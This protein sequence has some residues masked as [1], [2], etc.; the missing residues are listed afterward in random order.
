MK[1]LKVGSK[2][3]KRVVIGLAEPDDFKMLTKKRFSFVWKTVKKVATVYKLQ[4]EGEKD[5]L[6][7]MG[8]VDWQEEKRIEIKLLAS[9]VENIGKNKIYK[10]IAG[11]LIAFA[12]R[13]AVIRY[14][15]EACVSLVPKTELIEHYMQKYY[16][17]YAGRQL[18]LD[19]NNLIKLM[20]EYL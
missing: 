18:Y 11:C 20:E 2:I 4:I 17:Q 8:L 10:N 5:I 9:S 13:L 6:G 1:L 16:M 3:E 14:G 12:C 19:G 15:I 7:V